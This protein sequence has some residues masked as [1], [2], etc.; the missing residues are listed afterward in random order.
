[1]PRADEHGGEYVAPCAERLAWLT[2]FTGSAGLAVI[3]RNAA[4][5]FVD[6]RYTVQARAQIDGRMFEVLEIPGAR[7]S[8]WLE[9]KLAAGAVVGFDPWL[10]SA[11]AIEELAKAV[12]EKGIKLKPLARNPVDRAW[13]KARPAPPK[14]PV[15]PHALKY[16]GK[17]A[18]QK[19]SELQA[20]PAQGRPGRRGADAARFDRLAVQH[21]RLG[22]SAQSRRAGV[23]HRACH[24]QARVVRR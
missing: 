13:G 10:H 3:A 23:R 16:A 24:R 11:N 9:R 21:P 4:A 22:R 5:L 7:L 2:G 20:T 12:G 17:P 19:I 1:M 18:D 6:G 15:V 14:G 8:E